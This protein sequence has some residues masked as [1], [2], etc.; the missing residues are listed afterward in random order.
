MLLK[1]FLIYIIL[2]NVISFVCH[3]NLNDKVE[4]YV[5]PKTRIYVDPIKLKENGLQYFI[6]KHNGKL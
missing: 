1:F 2:Y 3:S 5:D 6:D 4:I